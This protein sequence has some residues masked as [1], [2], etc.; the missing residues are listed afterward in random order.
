MRKESLASLKRSEDIEFCF[1]FLSEVNAK[2]REHHEQSKNY[3]SAFWFVIQTGLRNS[4]VE[5]A[6]IQK[7]TDFFQRNLKKLKIQNYIIAFIPEE[8][9]EKETDKIVSC[10]LLLS[11]A[12]RFFVFSSSLVERHRTRSQKFGKSEM[13]LFRNLLEVLKSEEEKKGFVK[14]LLISSKNYKSAF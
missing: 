9:F 8:V 13:F 4:A 14:Q 11:P 5:G 1:K 2:I 12:G 10:L 6:F 3:F 7:A